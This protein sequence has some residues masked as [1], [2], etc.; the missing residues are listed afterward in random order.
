MIILIDNYDSFTYNIAQ[1]L[2]TLGYT[3]EVIRNNSLSVRELLDKEPQLVI[4]GP[5]PG[6]PS[7]AGISK[8]LIEEA[9]VPIFGICLGHQAIGEIFGARVV[10]AQQAVHGKVSLIHHG[11]GPLYQGLPTPFEAVRYHSLILEGLPDLLETEAWTDGGEIMGLR[12]KRKP[13]FG[14]QFHPESIATQYGLK[15]LENMVEKAS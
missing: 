11:G 14:V 8:K 1:G 5:G 6:K 15:V 2:Q 10:R 12:H 9:K 3:V 4:I 7:E 13:I